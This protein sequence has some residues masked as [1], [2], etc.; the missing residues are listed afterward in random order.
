MLA[1]MA[2][3]TYETD[4]IRVLWDS[5]R[6]I[7]VAACLKSAPEVFDTSNRPWVTVDGADAD[8]IAWAIEQCPSGA[9]QYERVDGSPQEM[10]PP[11]TSVVPWPGGPLLVR[12]DLSVR[13]ARERPIASGYRMALC[14]CGA[15]EN[16]P[17]C[18]LSHKRIGFRSAPHGVSEERLAAEKPSDLE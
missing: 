10:P 14:R 5:S 8:R 18:D 13:D 9:L 2:K 6:C 12:G 11:T 1:R 4:E 15:S 7:H 16:H 3:R 17:F